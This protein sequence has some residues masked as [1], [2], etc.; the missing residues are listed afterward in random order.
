MYNREKFVR[1]LGN[2]GVLSS[3][4]PEKGETV[5]LTID[6]NKVDVETASQ[7]GKFLGELYPENNVLIKLDGMTLESYM[8]DDLK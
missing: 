8:E 3:F 5:I 1:A 7:W 2:R 6:P 4:K